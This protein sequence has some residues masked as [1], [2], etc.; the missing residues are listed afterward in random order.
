MWITIIDC[1]L[2]KNKYKWRVNQNT[3]ILFSPERYGLKED[4]IIISWLRKNINK[5]RP[6]I[7]NQKNTKYII[8]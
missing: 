3:T 2:R 5:V 6:S 1:K 8:H 4:E 7:K